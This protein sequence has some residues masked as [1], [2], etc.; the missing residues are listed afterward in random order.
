MQLTRAALIATLLFSPL[1]A[2]SA[3]AERAAE[4]V[5]DARPEPS[6]SAEAIIEKHIAAL[7][8][9]RLLRSGTSFTYTVT[10]EKSGKK[11]SKTVTQVR[12]NKL[13]VDVTSD[14][15]PVSKGFDGKVAWSKKGSDPATAMS[16]ED[17]LAMQTYAQFEEPLVDH[18]KK[19]TKVKLVG[20]VDVGGTPTYDLELT[21]KNGDVE[22]LFIDAST[23]LLVKKTFT[24]K[25]KDGKPTPMAVR[26]GDYKK[27][28]GRMVNRSLAWE[29]NDGKPAKATISNVAYDKRVDAKL[30]A[31]P[32]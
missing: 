24:G 7:G 30:F 25:D 10:G 22:H 23:F 4:P 20:K 31:M 16:A 11:F 8:G 21:R 18:A 6:V 5:G 26:F 2:R 12:P 28:Q 9:E 13:R 15:G 32:Q 14:D 29:T 3:I 19:G 27:F 1:S 17:T